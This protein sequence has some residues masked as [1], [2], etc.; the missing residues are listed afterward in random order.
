MGHLEEKMAAIPTDKP[1]AMVCNDGYHSG[2]G[3][4]ILLHQGCREVYKVPGSM[5]DWRA[6]RHS[7]VR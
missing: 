6:A 3:V 4:S 2:L 5:T 7:G 1:A